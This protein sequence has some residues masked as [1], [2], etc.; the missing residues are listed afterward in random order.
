[1]KQ[2]KKIINGD[3]PFKI[4]DLNDMT[5]FYLWQVS[6]LWIYGQKRV[7]QKYHHISQMD[8]VVLSSTYWLTLHGHEV[9]QVYLS[10][11]TKIEPMGI[12]QL[13]KSLEQR[14]LIE[15]Q[16]NKHDNRSKVVKVTQ[17][18]IDL[19]KNAIITIE[20]L[21]ERFFK[22]LG[23]KLGVFNSFLADLLKANE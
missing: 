22:I 14:G 4:R 19:L 17:E 18:G 11:H 13:L 7:L 12:S 20:A 6:Y 10:Y 1:M 9:S 3:F 16:S 8:Y 23:K 5:G 15:R 21:D 2:D